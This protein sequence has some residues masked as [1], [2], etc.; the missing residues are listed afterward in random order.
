MDAKPPDGRKGQNC[1]YGKNAN[2]ERRCS[3]RSQQVHVPRFIII[4]RVH[5]RDL[6][7]VCNFANG[8]LCLENCRGSP[9][10]IFDLFSRYQ[11]WYLSASVHVEN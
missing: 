4:L 2:R 7:N 8:F 10:Y 11:P 5:T 6:E 1:D 3:T 9:Q